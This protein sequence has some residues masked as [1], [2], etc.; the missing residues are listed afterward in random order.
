MDMVVDDEKELHALKERAK[1]LACLYAIEELLRDTE[2]PLDEVFRG[3]LAAI[4]PGW[5]HPDACRAKIVHEGR[6]WQPPDFVET[7][8]EQCAPIFVQQRAVGRICVHYV[9]E[10][11]HSGDGPFLPEEVRL[12]GTIAERLGHY[13]RQR[14][15]ER[16]IGEH[17]RDAAQQAERRDAEWRGGL[18]LVRRT[19]Q[20]LYVRLA[21]KMLNHL[22]W[23]GVAE[24]QQVVERIGQ[25]ANG[26]APADAAENFPQQK[27]SLSREFYLSDEPFELAA[28]H[29]SDE[30][31]LERVQRW[32][33][34]DRSKF[35][36]KVLESQQSS[37]SEIADAVR[38]Y[39]Q[40]VPADAALSRATLEAMKVSLIS[41]FLTD[42]LDFIKVA[43]EYID[44]GAF[45]QLLDRL[46]FPAGSHGK[47]GGKSAGLF[48]ATQILR[49]AADAVPDGPRIKTPRSW[50]I[51]SDALLSFME[52]NDLG[53]AIQHKYKE[54]DQIRLEYPHLVQLYKHARF[55]PE[56][57]KGLSM[58]LDDF[59]ERPLIVRSSSLLEDRLGTAFSGKY[60]SLFLANQGGKEKRLEALMDAIA[61]IFASVFGPDPIEYR[62]ERGLLDF[63][64]EMGVLIQEVVGSRCGRFFLPAFSGVAF[65]HNEFRWSPRIRR[66]D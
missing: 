65:S 23:S 37:L 44:V 22:C 11:P 20:N 52:Y 30:E 8:W 64:E 51:A 55:P 15:L 34:E 27:R 63:K 12:V 66:E 24:A 57:V 2:R 3:V 10:L 33:F 26:D 29:L 50:Y 48:L 46:I 40:L 18:A 28:R 9:R 61:E 31:I 17:E 38:R 1:E 42:Q 56:I 54:I 32:M 41:R 25:D 47:L 13:L 62:R 36:V 35:L 43:K 49:R 53:D 16:L 6:T 58:A 21:R 14:K 19:D 45:M 4:P 39:Q 60:K 7:P 5:Q 59:G